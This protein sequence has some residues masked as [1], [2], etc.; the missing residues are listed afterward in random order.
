[1]S[2]EGKD[3]QWSCGKAGT[4]NLQRVGSIVRDIGE[5]CLH[6]SPTKVS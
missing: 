6:H 3:K 4:V 5:P 2:V 1:M